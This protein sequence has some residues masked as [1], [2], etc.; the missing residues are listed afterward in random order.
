MSKDY[1]AIFNLA[2]DESDIKALTAKR[3]IASVP[4]GSRFRVIDFMLSNVVN[5]GVTNVGIFTDTN[6]RS[7]V[8][9]IGDGKPWDLNRKNDGLFLFNHR[10]LDIANFDTKILQNNMEYL[11]RS[12]SD[13]VILTSSYMVCN[14]DLKKVIKSHESSGADVTVVYTETNNAD[15]EFL[16][17]YTVEVDE[18]HHAV[19]GIGKNIGYIPHASICMEI[20]ILKKNML[21]SL[22]QENARN[23]KFNDFYAL[24]LS[25]L[26][27]LNFNAYKF[28]GYVSCINSKSG[29]FKAN[30]DM[31]N[32]DVSRELFQSERPIYTKIKDEPPTIYVNGCSV[33][34][35]LVAD[36]TIIR[37]TVRNSIIG[38][39]AVVEEGAVVENSIILQNVRVCSGAHLSGAIIDK[40]V[41]ISENAQF[42]GD[43][44]FPT[45]VEKRNIYLP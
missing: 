22:I 6:S 13:S 17:C 8:D 37:G 15:R 9:H 23:R 3:S 11:F 18:E 31:L 14:I 30:M 27:V 40:N 24:L 43:E 25:K 1:M 44:Y 19:T 42:R 20:F 33:S 2:E 12:Q 35:S 36:G 29:Y 45:I 10:L 38:R 32:Q 4:I 16:N 39:F 28:E 34:N 21:I 7:L 26:K 41:V 5:A